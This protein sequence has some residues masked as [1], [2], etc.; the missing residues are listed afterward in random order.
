MTM[1]KRLRLI[2]CRCLLAVAKRNIQLISLYTFNTLQNTTTT[3]NNNN[4]NKNTHTN[5]YF[6]C[7][8]FDNVPYSLFLLLFQPHFDNRYICLAKWC[9]GL[10]NKTNGF[11]SIYMC[12]QKKSHYYIANGLWI[13]L[14]RYIQLS[15]HFSRGALFRSRSANSNTLS[16]SF[17]R[18]R[19]NKLLWNFTT[20]TAATTAPA[21]YTKWQ[22]P[23]HTNHTNI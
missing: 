4:D 1:L 15:V 18:W 16:S 19:E 12:R 13:I 22:S 14:A 10:I 23:L 5:I 11:F 9:L 20:I 8:P 3:N 7:P 17:D 6:L 21:K 2:C